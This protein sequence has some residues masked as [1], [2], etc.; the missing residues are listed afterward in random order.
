MING[1]S[2]GFFFH[3]TRG[4]KQGDSL[5]PTLYFLLVEVLSRALNSLHEDDLFIPGYGLPKWSANIN[6]LAYGDD[7]IIFTVANIYY[8]LK[9]MAILH[10]YETQSGQ[11]INKEKGACNYILMQ[12][13]LVCNGLRNVQELVGGYF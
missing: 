8:L 7:T 1:Q 11:I 2:Y 4:V 13:Q 3:S 5:S 6:H 9:I 10:E 12:R